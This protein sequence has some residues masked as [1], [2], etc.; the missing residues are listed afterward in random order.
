MFIFRYLVSRVIF[1]RKTNSFLF[2]AEAPLSISQDFTESSRQVAEECCKEHKRPPTIPLPS[3]RGRRANV[4]PY[5]NPIRITS[6]SCQRASGIPFHLKKLNPSQLLCSRSCAFM[7]DLSCLLGRQTPTR[8]QDRKK[9]KVKE[10]G[11]NMT[12]HGIFLRHRPGM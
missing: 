3:E 2:F 10:K 6:Q 4:V 1:V 5:L 7:C 9:R 11:N 8:S 12:E